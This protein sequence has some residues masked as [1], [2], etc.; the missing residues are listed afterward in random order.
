MPL[1]R[2]VSLAAFAAVVL[3]VSVGITA[4]AL[5]SQPQAASSDPMQGPANPSPFYVATFVDLMPPNI[6][7]GNAAIKDSNTCR[8]PART[9]VIQSWRSHRPGWPA[10]PT[11]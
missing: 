7:A 2:I 9:P 8:T 4:P 1:R 10:A 3:A 6:V 5:R 11:T